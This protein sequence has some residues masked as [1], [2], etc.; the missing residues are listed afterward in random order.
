LYSAFCADARKLRFSAMLK[1]LS[2]DAWREP[3]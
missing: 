3:C 2:L 1:H